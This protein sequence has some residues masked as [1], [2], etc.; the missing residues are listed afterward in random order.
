MRTR[1]VTFRTFPEHSDVA[2]SLLCRQALSP[3]CGVVGERSTGREATSQ[4]VESC[5]AVRDRD[6]ER[7]RGGGHGLLGRGRL[8]VVAMRSLPA[9]AGSPTRLGDFLIGI[10]GALCQPC[11]EG[12]SALPQAI[13]TLDLVTLGRSGHLVARR[14]RCAVCR[15][16]T[17]VFQLVD[18]I[19][20]I[21]DERCG[22][23]R[24]AMTGA[25]S[26]LDGVPDSEATHA[27]EATA[28]TR[29]KRAAGR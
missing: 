21:D 28:A 12:A 26:S 17:V 4:H 6:R 11:I 15:A 29:N 10:D 8:P 7:G 23:R 18:A 1:G 25:W 2:A 27:N 19:D 5:P 3:R 24:V 14:G 20:R 9:A 16:A 13:V 22:A